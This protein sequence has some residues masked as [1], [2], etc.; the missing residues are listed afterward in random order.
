MAHRK[1][2]IDKPPESARERKASSAES[3]AFDVLSHI[4]LQCLPEKGF[5]APSTKVAPM[6]LARIGSRWRAIAMSTPQLW[7][8]INL[9]DGGSPSHDYSKDSMA[10]EEWRVL[11]GSC[12]LS[13]RIAYTKPRY[14][15]NAVLDAILPHHR[16][17]KHMECCLSFQAWSRL[18][19]VVSRS[20]LNLRY[21]E[22]KGDYSSSTVWKTTVMNVTNPGC[23][24]LQSLLL[25][26]CN[27]PFDLIDTGAPWLRKVVLDFRRV[28]LTMDECCRFLHHCPNLEI[29]AAHC[30]SL[31]P[32]T[33]PTHGSKFIAARHLKKLC[34]VVEL[35]V[36]WQVFD[37]LY[38]PALDTLDLADFD[39]DLP[40][41]PHLPSFFGRSGARLTS[42]NLGLD[43]TGDEF[44]DSFRKLPALTS[45]QLHPDSTHDVLEALIMR[46]MNRILPLLECI[47]FTSFVNSQT[48]LVANI[49][50][51]R[52]RGSNGNGLST[53][54][55]NEKSGNWERRLRSVRLV[56]RV[57]TSHTP[58]SRVLIPR[59]KA[60]IEEG[61]EV[62][63]DDQKDTDINPWLFAANQ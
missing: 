52:W 58:C 50:L 43:M 7:T 49:V 46:P 40:G 22:V 6:L 29:F 12:L 15:L 33:T 23:P 57:H 20:A 47:T 61:L 19:S 21:L 25:A 11:A 9:S 32:Q 24:N 31:E 39:Y 34:L 4:F 16:Q 54:T 2:D 51:S 42:M 44:R 30:T 62:I 3:L 18:H 63:E 37:R 38:A 35:A 41:Y 56:G 17:W 13:Y 55:T 28:E 59:I 8:D 1:L 48:D 26:D 14:E 60:C 53:N 10:A 27:I 5:P 45:L 36:S